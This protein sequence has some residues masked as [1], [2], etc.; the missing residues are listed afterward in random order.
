V[1]AGGVVHDLVLTDIEESR[2]RRLE[3]ERVHGDLAA[4]GRRQGDD[5]VAA[6]V[7]RGDTGIGSPSG[8]GPPARVTE[9]VSS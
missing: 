6:A 7:H 2:E 1:Q 4:V 5:V 3:P 8:F 9:S